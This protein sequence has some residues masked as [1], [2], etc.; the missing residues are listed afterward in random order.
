M[1]GAEKMSGSEVRRKAKTARMAA[2]KLAVAEEEKKNEALEAMATALIRHR[3]RIFSANETDLL[4]GEKAGLPPALMDRLR[5]T[6]KR[7]EE[8]GEG[9]C[10]LRRMP[11]P[12]GEILDSRRREDGLR[13]EKVRVPLGVI[14]MI[15]EARPNVTVDAAGLALKAGNAVV[16]RGSSSASRTNRALTEALHRA[17]AGTS[18][19]EEAVQ[20]VEDPDRQAVH[21]LITM[22]GW[23]DVIIPRGGAGLIRRVVRESTVPVLETGVGNCH[24]YVDRSAKSAMAEEIVINAKTDRPAVCNAVE[25]LLVHRVWAE[26]HLPSL[27]EKLRQQGVQ[28]KGCS[29]TRALFP[30]ADEAGEEDWETEFLD[31]VLPFRIVDSLE[32]A[33][34]HIDRY[35]SRHSEAIITEDDTAARTFMRGVEAAAVYHN[36]S[37][38]FTDGSQFGFGAEIGISTQ[39][40]HAR[41]PMGVTELTSYQYR[42]HGTGQ[43]R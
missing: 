34:E 22:N 3:D 20:L 29:R 8:M 4:Q 41:G 21:E 26:K 40:L 17:L 6:R 39:K 9:L 1:K 42:I 27:C 28:V 35:G 2:K 30:Q 12:V 23:I 10:Q 5:L 31:L 43:V 15:Y 32:D 25:T 36:A 11:D 33:V 7:L 16:L 13:I 14:G 19:P 18:L 37:T 38:R 24:I